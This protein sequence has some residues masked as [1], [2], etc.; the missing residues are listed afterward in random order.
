MAV[1]I[2]CH[3]DGRT[4]PETLASLEGQEPHELVVVDDGSTDPETLDVL[5]RLRADGVQVIRQDNAGPAAARMAGVAATAARYVFPLDADDLL[6]RG[7]LETLADAL[8]ADPSAVAAWGDEPT[9][10]RSHVTVRPPDHLDP[11]LVTFL[12]ELPISAAMRREAL[13][14]AGGWQVRS[15]Y[16]DW[17]L[18]MSLA[19]GGYDGVRVPRVIARY[20]VHGSR[21]WADNRA[22]HDAIF[23]E[24]RSRHPALFAERGRNWRRS[25]AP[26]RARLLL[27]LLAAMPF[28]S[29]YRLYRL[30]HV[31]LH[32]LRLLRVRLARR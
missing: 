17:D 25:R 22:R 13:V 18:W 10:G 21:R 30:S 32:P 14:A 26:L 7:A 2:P 6:E 20:R 28:R 11:W 19:E 9:F 16:E 4:L 31:V 3:D 1:V 27:P 12:N 29:H 8:D 15:G 23:D 24:L 5:E